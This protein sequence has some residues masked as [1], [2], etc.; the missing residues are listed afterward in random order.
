MAGEVSF[1]KNKEP[2]EFMRQA[3][4]SVVAYIFRNDLAEGSAFT[5]EDVA[6]IWFSNDE[7]QGWRVLLGTGLGD[8][9]YYRVSHKDGETRL[10]VFKMFDSQVL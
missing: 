1:T 10:D 6:I 3:R 8:G 2:F 7:N 4:Y 9:R 5:E